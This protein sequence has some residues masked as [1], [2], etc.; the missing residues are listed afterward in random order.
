MVVVGRVRNPLRNLLQELFAM[1]KEWLLVTGQVMFI[2]KGFIEQL[3][4]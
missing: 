2:Q 1:Q 4:T 3:H